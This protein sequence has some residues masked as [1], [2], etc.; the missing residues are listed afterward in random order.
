MKER[1]SVGCNL[2]I[3]SEEAEETTVTLTL[4]DDTTLECVVINIFK[5]M[6]KE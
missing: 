1:Q 2:D 6:D 3:N 5:A 4:D